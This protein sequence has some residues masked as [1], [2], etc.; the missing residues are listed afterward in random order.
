M[1]L[2]LATGKNGGQEKGAL[3]FMCVWLLG[4]PV[5]KLLLFV[6]PEIW[7]RSA[8]EIGLCSPSDVSPHVLSQ[9]C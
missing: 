5:D 1:Q 3:L 9:W 6:G 8:L 7:E 4:L 2:L